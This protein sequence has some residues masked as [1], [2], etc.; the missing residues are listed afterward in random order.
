MRVLR[1]RISRS[2][3]GENQGIDAAT[4]RAVFA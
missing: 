3:G 1:L 2:N 4:L